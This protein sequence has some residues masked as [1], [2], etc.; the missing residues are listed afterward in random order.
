MFE[1]VHRIMDREEVA[2]EMKERLWKDSEVGGQRRWMKVLGSDFYTSG[3]VPVDMK[4]RFFRLRGQGGQTTIFIV[5]D[6]ESDAAAAHAGEMENHPTV[7]SVASPTEPEGITELEKKY[8]NRL[9]DNPVLARE[10]AEM[11]D[12]IAAQEA[13]LRE[14]RMKVELY[15]ET[16]V[17]GERARCHA[18]MRQIMALMDELERVKTVPP[19]EYH[20]HL[21]MESRDGADSMA[22]T[23]GVGE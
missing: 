3:M 14:C 23:D 7:V 8:L 18:M 19:E 10:N 17:R 13:E 5:P 9:E 21:G 1:M 16:M 11:K 2:I 6:V 12:T 15:E 4:T 20:Q 22:C